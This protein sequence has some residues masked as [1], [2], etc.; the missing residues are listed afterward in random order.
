MVRVK[1]CGIT[2]LQDA[3]ASADLGAYALGFNF[4]EKSVR[5]VSPAA[6][7]RIVRG[8]PEKI[9]AV[10]VFVNWS[11]KTVIAMAQAVVLR[12]VQLHGNESP[13]MV[14]TVAKRF[15]VTKALRV[16]PGFILARLSPYKAASAYL[17][18]AAKAGQYGGTGRRTDWAIA[19]L[20]AKRHR[21]ILAGGITPENVADGDSASCRPYAVDVC[22]GVES[23]PGKERS[24]QVA[25]SFYAEVERAN[26]ELKSKCKIGPET[27]S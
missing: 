4:Y 8:L 19:R 18:D 7:Y 11:A 22:S 2:N 17:F 23:K 6:A 15:D 1:I 5:N 16:G 21:I 13:E 12:T 26:R 25:A 20:A 24:R 3:K 27:Q 10:G 9:E 14:R